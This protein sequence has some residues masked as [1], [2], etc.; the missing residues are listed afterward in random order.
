[1]TATGRTRASSAPLTISVA[2]CTFNGERFLSQQLES[3][4]AQERLPDELV[5][6]DDNSS[7]STDRILEEFTLKAAFPVRVIRN[8][9]NLGSTQSFDNTICACNGTIVALADQDDLWFPNKLKQ[10][11]AAF[12]DAPEAV[13]VF[14]DAEIIDDDSKPVGARLWE[15]FYFS[16]R[17]Q[18]RL[19]KGG[20]IEVLIK[21]PVVT[22]ATMAFRKEFV[23]L[24]SPIPLNHVHDSWISFLLAVCGPFVPLAEPLMQYRRHS[25]QQIGAGPVAL[26]DR[27]ARARSTGSDFYL[28]EIAR[29]ADFHERLEQRGIGLPSTKRALREIEAKIS[30]REHRARLPRTSLARLPKV[31]REAING[32]Y[33]RYSEGWESVAKDLFI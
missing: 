12:G 6:S 28:Q 27:L 9:V 7:D 20:A 24:I 10:I 17:E 13:A 16:S 14:S 15:S 26:R 2:M 11:E 18:E 5:V 32:H 21:H 1:L 22:G 25:S 29:F 19:A 23:S 31:I 4:S 30:H 3:I 8:P 33:W